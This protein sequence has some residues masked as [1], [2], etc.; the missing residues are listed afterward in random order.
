MERQGS[1]GIV[2]H[3]LYENQPFGGMVNGMK[4]KLSET[5]N[6]LDYCGLVCNATRLT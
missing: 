2:Q 1:S 6:G 5:D 3:I 4:R